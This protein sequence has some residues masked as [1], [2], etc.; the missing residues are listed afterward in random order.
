MDKLLHNLYLF[1]GLGTSDL[2]LI[3][4]IALLRSFAAGDEIFHQGDIA[5]SF[6][7]IQYGSVRIDQDTTDG[8]RVEVAALGTGSH[9]GEMSL[10]DNELRSATATSVTNSDIIGISYS[11][12]NKLLES[13]PHIAIHFYYELSRFLCSRLRLTTIDLSYSK[14]QNISYF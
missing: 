5:E 13:H 14:S 7:V 4:D 9:F 3:E 10:L 11:E 2:Q 6:Y 8:N 12:I 1:K